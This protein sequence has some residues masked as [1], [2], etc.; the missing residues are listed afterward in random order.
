MALESEA[1][2]TRLSRAWLS[3]C[4]RI[5]DHI[6]S[7]HLPEQDH[8]RN[9]SYLRPIAYP[10]KFSHTFLTLRNALAESGLD[11]QPPMPRFNGCTATSLVTLNNRPHET[12]Y[13]FSFLDRSRCSIV[14]NAILTLFIQP[15]MYSLYFT[16]RHNG[17]TWR[18][19]SL[20]FS[21]VE[22]SGHVKRV[23]DPVITVTQRTVSVEIY[24]D[25]A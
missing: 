25:R 10:E 8:N 13:G 18:S 5:N 3:W 2:C 11:C 22:I 12:W 20:L 6:P 21:F 1:D 23:K 16:I 9:R 7:N 15:T 24:R 17:R 14:P 19:D 4:R